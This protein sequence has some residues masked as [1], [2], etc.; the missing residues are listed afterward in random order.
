VLHVA[1][2]ADAALVAD[3]VEFWHDV[4]GFNMQAMMEKI[5][6]DVLVRTASPETMAGP[7]DPFLVLPLHTVQVAD[8]TFRR[9]FA[10]TVSETVENLDGWALWFDTFFLP[11]RSSTLSLDARAEL[12][13]ASNRPGN[14]FTTGPVGKET[15]WRSGIMIIDRSKK[16]PRVVP[17][18][19]KITGTIGYAEAGANKRSLEIE[20]T[21]HV[22]GSNEHGQQIW[23]V[24]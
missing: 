4:Y 21:W 10:V 11:S 8:L 13:A 16:P 15:H 7:S 1:P 12:W 19:T 24:H 5:Y 6:D 17:R 3:N 14:A 9:P 23:Y 20:I 22:D 2:L 18:G